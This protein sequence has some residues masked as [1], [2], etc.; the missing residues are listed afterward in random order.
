MQ[1]LIVIGGVAAVMAALNRLARRSERDGR[2]DVKSNSTAIR[3]GLRSFFDRGPG[4]FQEDGNRQR[5][6]D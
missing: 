4:G 5:T 6:L 2:Y 1:V 3:P